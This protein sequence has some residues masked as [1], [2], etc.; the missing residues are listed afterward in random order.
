[1]SSGPPESGPPESGPPAAVLARVVRAASR[2]P[3]AEN[4]QPWTFRW[5]GR[6][7]QIL[8]DAQRARKG[9]DRA[10]HDSLLSLGC[11]LVAFEVAA[12]AEGLALVVDLQLDEPDHV[13]WAELRFRTGPGRGAELAVALARRCTDR[14]PFRGGSPDHP[15]FGTIRAE[16]ERLPRVGLATLGPPSGR[17]L[18]FFQEAEGL[19]W[20]HEPTWVDVMRWLRVSQREVE[21][22]RDGASWRCMGFDLPELPGLSRLRSPRTRALLA[23]AGAP[24]LAAAW[25]AHQLRSAGALVLVTVREPGRAA[26]VDAGRLMMLAWLHLTEADHGVQ[27]HSQQS[28][29]LHEAAVGTLPAD[30]GPPWRAR[31]AAGLEQVS[32][33][34]ALGP[35]ELPVMLL[36]TGISDSPPDWRW[37]LRRSL[38]ELL[39][40]G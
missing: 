30:L 32:S 12:A 27:P 34:F 3:S 22:S 6:R 36:R 17:L 38:P 37:T 26:L 15:V 21:E 16:A 24:R 19:V 7:L 28:F 10:F 9:Q 18:S 40:R 29:F 33:A 1:M 35:G 14:R 31:Y 2:A 20:S 5:D 11:L 23:R 25:H 39:S 4:C 13:C 8:H